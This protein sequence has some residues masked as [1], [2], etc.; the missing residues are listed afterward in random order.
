VEVTGFVDD[1]RPFF[2]R[3][4][5]AVSPLLYGAGTQYKVLEA[6]ICGVPVVATPRVVGGLQAHPGKDYLVG[7]DG[8][9]FARHVIELINAPALQRGIGQAGRQYVQRHHD[10][11]RIARKLVTVYTEVAA[12][13]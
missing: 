13:M 10:W 7:D 3:A 5:L 4:T 6:M 12:Q 2:A 8:D 9:Q 1:L 11:S